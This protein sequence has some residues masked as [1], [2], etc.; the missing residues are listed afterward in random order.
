MLLAYSKDFLSNIYRIPV[1]I[2][3]TIGHPNILT[4]LGVAYKKS[5]NIGEGK[6]RNDTKMTDMLGGTYG[7]P[8]INRYIK[9]HYDKKISKTYEYTFKIDGQRDSREFKVYFVDYLGNSRSMY[10]RYA[11]NVYMILYLFRNLNTHC[12]KSLSIYFYM[13]PFKK[14]LPDSKSVVLSREHINTGLTY[15]CVENNTICVYRREEWFKVFI[16]ELFHAY[17][18][19]M[20][21]SFSQDVF[22]IDEKVMVGESY[23]EFWAVYFNSMIIAFHLTKTINSQQRNKKFSEYLAKIIRAER[24]FSLIQVNKI[25]RYNGINYLDLFKKNKYRE[26]T[27]IFA[28]FIIKSILLFHYSDFI[29]Q[30]YKNNK[31]KYT[32]GNDAFIKDFI[33]K[34]CKNMAYRKYLK[35]LNVDYMKTT[36]R[37]TI[38][39]LI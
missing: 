39:E 31:D 20:K 6:E 5:I 24:I 23:V 14:L 4:E 35:I 38:M 30:C 2:N 9:E 32:V 1:D 7:V 28:Y 26:K 36:L 19:D 10:D 3:F 27:N 25:L 22:K 15:Q 29:H 34:Y 16:H 8:Y 37:M 33:N 18:T 12:S 21:I 13:T 11:R 17:G